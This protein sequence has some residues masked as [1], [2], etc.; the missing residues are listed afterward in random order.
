MICLSAD[1]GQSG[2]WFFFEYVEKV[3][4]LQFNFFCDNLAGTLTFRASAI[5]VENRSFQ[6]RERGYSRKD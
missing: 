2:G 1:I 5:G 3:N 4:I 6:E